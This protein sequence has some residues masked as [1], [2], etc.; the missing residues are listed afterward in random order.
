MGCDIHLYTEQ[1]IDG[2][3]QS[4]DVWTKEDGEGHMHVAYEHKL[5]GDR[6]YSLFAILANV[7]NGYGFAGVKTGDGFVPISEPR[8]LPVDVSAQVKTSSD[9]WDGDGHSHSHLTLREI[10]DADWNQ[11]TVRCG[12]VRAE[13]YRDWRNRGKPSAWSGDVHGPNVRKV[14]VDEMERIC[15]TQEDDDDIIC[16]I[17]WTEYYHELLG[18]FAKAVFRA[19]HKAAPEDVRFVFWFDN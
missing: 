10:L 3:W 1:R 5:Y 12:Y 16:F 7:R 14:S 19:L 11:K 6:N 9:R 13:G 15:T 8:G 18:S 17:E 2:K 4:V